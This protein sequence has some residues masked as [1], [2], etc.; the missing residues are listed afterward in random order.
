MLESTSTNTSAYS[1]PGTSASLA[2]A[3]FLHF[4]SNFTSP[5]VSLPFLHTRA[6]PTARRDTSLDET[7]RTRQTG[8]LNC[9]PNFLQRDE[10]ETNVLY[11]LLGFSP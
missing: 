2:R 5:P 6:P 7:A 11:L 4:I 3:G 1:P 8:P 10:S 9:W